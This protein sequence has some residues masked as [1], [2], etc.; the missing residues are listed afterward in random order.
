[1]WQSQAKLY[2][3]TASISV[4]FWRMKENIGSSKSTTSH[5][6]ITYH[7][8]DIY[9]D[10]GFVIYINDWI[11]EN[12]IFTETVIHEM[13]QLEYSVDF[14]SYSAC[15][16][17]L[18]RHRVSSDF[19]FMFQY[20][21]S[22]SALQPAISAPCLISS[23]FFYLCSATALSHQSFKSSNCPGNRFPWGSYHHISLIRV[24]KSSVLTTLI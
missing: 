24:I 3:V 14:T 19:D 23:V 21:V 18:W 5:F 6:R 10:C 1:M 20:S 13:I 11:V 16:S 15:K 22:F 7:S 17:V 8:R 4:K 9:L 2:P 12:I